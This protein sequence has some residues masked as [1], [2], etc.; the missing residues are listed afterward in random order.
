MI[1]SWEIWQSGEATSTLDGD[2]HC[3]M[4][5]TALGRSR[6]KTLEKDKRKSA[7]WAKRLL[8]FPPYIISE[9]YEAI[10][11]RLSLPTATHA[12]PGI[13]IDLFPYG[14]NGMMIATIA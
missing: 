14:S 2:L 11:S 1:I 5:L 10:T 8:T 13:Y 3:P 12:S 7:F 9:I 4:L 6:V